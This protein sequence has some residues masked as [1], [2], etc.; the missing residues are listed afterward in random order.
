VFAQRLRRLWRL[1]LGRRSQRGTLWDRLIPTFQGFQQ[2]AYCILILSN[3]SSPPIKG[4]SRMRKRAQKVLCGGRSAVVVPT[5]KRASWACHT[6]RATEIT[7]Y[8]EKDGTIENAQLI[9]AHESPRKTKLY[10]RTGDEITL[11]APV[12]STVVQLPR[13]RLTGSRNKWNSSPPST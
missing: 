13:D 7:A 9:A 4:G 5:H 11:E 3:A 2:P 6:F 10:D 1:I 12:T 8:F